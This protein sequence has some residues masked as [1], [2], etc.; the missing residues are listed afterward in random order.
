MVLRHV[1]DGRVLAEL[2][3]PDV[4]SDTPTI[5]RLNAR[6]IAGH[7]AKAIGDDVE[8]M[9]HGCFDQLVGVIGGG[10][11][12][13]APHYHA[14]AVADAAV[15]RRAINVEAFLAAQQVGSGDGERKVGNVH[16]VH[17]A[18]VAGLVDV[19][20]AAGNGAFDHGARRAAVAKK[21][22]GR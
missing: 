3:N 11:A 5:V 4:S 22:G 14:I 12:E 8:K 2:Q 6:R 15:T 7:G 10:L 19:Q 13:A 21:I 20:V 17:F 9:S 1:V 18:R 16:A